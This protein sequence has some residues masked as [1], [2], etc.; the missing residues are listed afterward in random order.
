[1][2]VEGTFI[3]SIWKRKLISRQ[4][5][6]ILMRILHSTEFSYAKSLEMFRK[7]AMGLKKSFEKPVV[8]DPETIQ[9]L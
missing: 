4:Y 2:A 5:E 7:N 9:L 6:G 3:V 8:L 1:M